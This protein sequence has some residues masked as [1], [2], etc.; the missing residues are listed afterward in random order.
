[1]RITRVNFN[2]KEGKACVGFGFLF[3]GLWIIKSIHGFFFTDINTKFKEC[4]LTKT[5]ASK[6]IKEW[7]QQ[8]KTNPEYAEYF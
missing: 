8:V 5:Y 3:K 1:M 2:N 4:K 6:L 7:K